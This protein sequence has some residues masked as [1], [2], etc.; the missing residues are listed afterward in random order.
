MQ[1]FIA[2]VVAE[3][4]D[5]G[6]IDFDEASIRAAEKQ[7]FLNV[8]EQFAIA[9][10]GF[11]AVGDVLQNMNGLKA[12]VAGGM[13]LRSGDQIGALQ[14]RVQVLVGGGQPA[15]RQKGQERVGVLMPVA[16]RAPMLMPISC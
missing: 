16:S 6:V 3:H 11:A 9:A 12:F 8:V 2:A 1:Q 13:N 5:Q 7:S 4:A 14:R 15:L 10:F